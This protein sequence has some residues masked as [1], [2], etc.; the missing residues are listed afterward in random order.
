MIHAGERLR[1]GCVIQ[2]NSVEPAKSTLGTTS[3]VRSS[4]SWHQGGITPGR[5][6]VAHSC[7]SRRPPLCHLSRHILRSHL[8]CSHVHALL[9]RGLALSLGRAGLD[10]EL[11]PGFPYIIKMLQAAENSK[12]CFNYVL[13]GKQPESWVE[14][15]DRNF[16]FFLPGYFQWQKPRTCPNV[17]LKGKNVRFVYEIITNNL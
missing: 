17:Y 13:R 14:A 8:T 1:L 4:Q 6:H 9:M 11:L 7:G 5:R 16:F 3:M 2:L 10:S 15:N 12:C